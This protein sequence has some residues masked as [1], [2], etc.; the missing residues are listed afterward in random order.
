MNAAE[1]IDRFATSIAQYPVVAL[2]VA[3]AGGVFS[4]TT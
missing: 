2:L 4:T 3:I 1:L